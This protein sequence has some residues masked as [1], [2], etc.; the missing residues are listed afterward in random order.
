MYTVLAGA[1]LSCKQ[2][3][4]Y[5][6]LTGDVWRM[7]E[8]Y[9]VHGGGR[10]NRQRQGDG[11]QLQTSALG[12]LQDKEDESKHSQEDILSLDLTNYPTTIMR[13]QVQRCMFYGWHTHLMEQHTCQSDVY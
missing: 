7:E 11:Q 12:E 2:S 3:Y 4:T 5:L 8:D 1:K 9:G 6:R 10:S 13:W